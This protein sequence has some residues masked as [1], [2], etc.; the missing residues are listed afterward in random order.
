[1]VLRIWKNL[2]GKIRRLL[3]G[4]LRP[5]RRRFFPAVGDIGE[6]VALGFLLR[7]GYDVVA[8]NVR[9]GSG[10]LDMIAFDQGTLVFVEVK[11]RSRHDGYAPQSAVTHRKEEQLM[12][13]ARAFC[14][15]YGLEKYPAR[16]DVVAVVLQDGP[17][18]VEH[19]V[20]AFRK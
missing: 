14:H 20:G 3:R 16:F 10:E 9:I 18:H 7:R 13:L 4:A 11:T 17:P 15:R 2:H 6:T 12:R 1:M 5:A 8:R 19:F